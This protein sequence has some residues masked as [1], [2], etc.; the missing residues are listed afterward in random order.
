M[1]RCLNQAKCDENLTKVDGITFYLTRS[2]IKS[3]SESFYV[4]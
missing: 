1:E 2:S 3:V 4:P